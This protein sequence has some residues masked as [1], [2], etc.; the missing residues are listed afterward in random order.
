MPI[1]DTSSGSLINRSSSGLAISAF[2]V[3]GDAAPSV[4]PPFEGPSCFV[5]STK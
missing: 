2:C 4:T 1:Y 5:S 3:A